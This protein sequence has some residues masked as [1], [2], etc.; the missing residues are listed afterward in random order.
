[1][2]HYSFGRSVDYRDEKRHCRAP[3]PDEAEG[4]VPRPGEVLYDIAVAFAG[5]LA[6][7]LLAQFI[8]MAI[9]GG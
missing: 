5:F 2:Q 1:M 9:G 8:V 4:R 3:L 7:A 6:I